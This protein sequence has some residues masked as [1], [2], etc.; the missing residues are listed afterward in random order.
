MEANSPF[1][2]HF[3]Y[4]VRDHGLRFRLRAEVDCTVPGIYTVTNI[5]PE[6]QK[7]G[8]LLPPIRLKKVDGSWILLDNGQESNLSAS[9][10]QAIELRLNGVNK[11]TAGHSDL[12]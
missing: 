1:S 10:G 2:I 8:S 9:I 12:L 3:T 7:E 6:F 11:N 4:D 5:L